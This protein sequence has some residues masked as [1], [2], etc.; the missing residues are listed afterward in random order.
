MNSRPNILIVDDTP[1][2][3]DILVELLGE[4]ALTVSLEGTEA[5]G[6]AQSKPIDLILLDIMMPDPDGFTVCARLKADPATREIPIIFIT[7]KSDEESIERAYG[8]GG[9]DYITKPFRPREVLARVKLLL[10]RADYLRQL[11]FLASHDPMT[12]IY[13]R[14]KFFEL[15]QRC[16]A[17]GAL[18]FMAGGVI[19]IDHFK[20]INDAHGHPAGDEVI[21][22]ICTVIAQQLPQNVLFGRL[23]GEEFGLAGQFSSKADAAALVEQCRRAV[24][25]LEIFFEGTPLRCTVSNGIAFKSAAID[26]LD[27]LLG[28]ADRALYEA[29]QC[30]RNRLIVRT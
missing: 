7:A 14:R 25:S 15:A 29:K 21:R 30:G 5:L 10:E 2:N 26:T 23:G 17:Q 4:Y 12:G 19:D 24:E 11:E 1:E 16:F 3:L 9:E 13:N 22:S 28:E 18:P 8:A 20:A 27:K 6:I